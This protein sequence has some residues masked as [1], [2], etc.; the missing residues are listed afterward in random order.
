M[1]APNI[2]YL[3][4][5]HVGEQNRKKNKAPKPPTNDGSQTENNEISNLKSNMQ[6]TKSKEKNVRETVVDNGNLSF[7]GKPVQTAETVQNIK[8]EGNNSS[9]IANREAIEDDEERFSPE[10]EN[11]LKTLDAVI[12]EVEDSLGKPTDTIFGV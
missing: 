12:Q 10:K 8:V 11:A 4:T 1:I 5:L 9:H 7:K 3:Y 2:R 6:H